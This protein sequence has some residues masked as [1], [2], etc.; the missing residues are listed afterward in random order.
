MFDRIMGCLG[1]IILCWLSLL[2]V[3]L[4]CV[5]TYESYLL[6]IFRYFN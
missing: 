3:T 4:L 2:L 5:V 1:I 6:I